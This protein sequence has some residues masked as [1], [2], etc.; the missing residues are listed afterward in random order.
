MRTHGHVPPSAIALVVGA[1]LC[2][3]ILDAIVKTLVQRYPV[4]MIVWARYSVQAL[5]VLLWL[6]PTMGTSLLRTRRLKL[7]LA[8]A[9]LLPIS[10][11]CFFSALRYLPLAE[12]TAI[13]Y[14]SPILVI[15]LA[16][17]FLDECSAHGKDI[18]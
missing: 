5:V 2:F 13:N 14:M 16:V 8:R 4:P 12:T 10:S 6:F 17:L 7:H 3:T 1:V 18:G 11:I 15:V 9:V